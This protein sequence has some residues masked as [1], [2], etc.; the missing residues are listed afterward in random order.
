VIKQVL[1]LEHCPPSEG[2]TPQ[3]TSRTQILNPKLPRLYQE[4][5][6]S[7][8]EVDRDTAEGVFGPLS[9]QVAHSVVAKNG[10]TF[11]MRCSRGGP[12]ANSLDPTVGSTLAESNLGRLP[13]GRK[14]S[15]VNSLDTSQND[16]RSNNGSQ[17]RRAP[18]R[19][20]Q[21]CMLALKGG[22]VS[23]VARMVKSHNN[24]DGHAGAGADCDA[25]T[26]AADQEIESNKDDS[27]KKYNDDKDINSED[28]V[29]DVKGNSDEDTIDQD[30]V[31]STVDAEVAEPP[32]EW[33]MP[34][35]IRNRNGMDGIQNDIVDSHRL[36]RPSA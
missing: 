29:D 4:E 18:S 36:G 14:S 17:F 28:E 35:A 27:N 32:A 1:A 5:E 9:Y 19:A 15:P 33:E 22:R 7:I 20:A 16:S 26:A 8:D 34:Q 23:H 12:G 31:K 13:F 25:S 6:P 3:K 21:Q 24:D 30:E 10:P 11:C 2:R